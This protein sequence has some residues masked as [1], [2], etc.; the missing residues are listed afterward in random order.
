[1]PWRRRCV[2]KERH[3]DL[4]D[5]PDENLPDEV[6]AGRYREL[7]LDA[8]ARRLKVVERPAFT[9][10]GGMDSSSVLA[11]A[12]EVTGERQVAYS[13]TYEDKTYDESADI[14][15]ALDKLVSRWRRVHVG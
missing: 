13:V 9:L 3:W 7:F 8:V 10:S 6:L 4:R 11:A 2:A 15:D 1:V 5:L 12:V 14:A